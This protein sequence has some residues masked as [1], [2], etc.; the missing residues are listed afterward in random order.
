MQ[1]NSN[2]PLEKGRILQL[3]SEYQTLETYS[4]VNC[5]SEFADRDED[6]TQRVCVPIAIHIPQSNYTPERHTK[7]NFGVTSKATPMYVSAVCNPSHVTAQGS[8]GT[9]TKQYQKVSLSSG[10][11]NS[12][13][14][15]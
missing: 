3:C 2:V 4:N 7:R 15:E 9:R 12:L 13:V 11:F 8:L 5:S 1:S 6:Y 10:K 14:T